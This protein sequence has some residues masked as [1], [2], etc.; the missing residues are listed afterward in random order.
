MSRSIKARL[1]AEYANFGALLEDESRQ[2]MLAF[3]KRAGR[4][5]SGTAE[6][7]GEL[8]DAI[9]A[10]NACY[11]RRT[12]YLNTGV[13]TEYVHKCLVGHIEAM[14]MARFYPTEVE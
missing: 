4:L 13:G 2:Y 14:L 7:A 8:L 3:L 1:I 5:P 9:K 6:L 11:D 10:W 12:G